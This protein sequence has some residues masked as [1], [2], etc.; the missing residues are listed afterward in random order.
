MKYSDKI[1]E[2][3][4]DMAGKMPSDDNL[5]S[6]AD[7]QYKKV[8]KSRKKIVSYRAKPC[9]SARREYFDKLRGIELDLQVKGID[10]SVSPSFSV[11]ALSWC[12][13]V[14]LCVPIEVRNKEDV[15][16]LEELA[17]RLIK[18][19]TT[20]ASEFHGIG[21]GAMSGS[22]KL[23]CE[24]TIIVAMRLLVNCM[25]QFESLS[26]MLYNS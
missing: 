23:D 9:S 14:S 21:M 13:G 1:E 7:K 16:A 10:F 6:G 2:I 3:S 20:L 26:V 18:G 4:W 12:R 19:E 22:G 11:E 8:G 17:R 25:R 24:M 15:K 5:F